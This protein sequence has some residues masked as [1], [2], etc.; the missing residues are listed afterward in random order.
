MFSIAH[1]RLFFAWNVPPLFSNAFLSP[2]FASPSIL[3]PPHQPLTPFHSHSYLCG[4]PH[5]PSVS[6][7]I[8]FICLLTP[9]CRSSVPL[10]HQVNSFRR[11]LMPLCRLLTLF[12]LPYRLLI[13]FNACPSIFN[14]SS[15]PINCFSIVIYC[16]MVALRRLSIACYRIPLTHLNAFHRPLTLLLSRLTSFHRLLTSLR[17]YL[18]L[19]HCPLATLLYF[20]RLLLNT[21][22]SLLN[23]F[24][25][26]VDFSP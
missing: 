4:T 15:S 7:F 17:S 1:Y 11:T 21:F 6:T 14:S 24:L 10:C 12:H 20:K 5:C 3:T 22:Y 2:F 23:A 25:S 8:I 26:P 13:E 9:S 16:F 18:M 19:L